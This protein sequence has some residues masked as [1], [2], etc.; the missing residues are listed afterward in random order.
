MSLRWRNDGRRWRT[1]SQTALRSMHSW[2]ELEVKRSDTLGGV[3]KH[4]AKEA[5]AQ[6][7]VDGEEF[8]FHD[9]L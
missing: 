5:L 1:S 2:T 7:D 3:N 8:R 9:F 4:R 6:E